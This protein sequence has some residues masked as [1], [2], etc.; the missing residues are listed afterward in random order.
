MITINAQMR[1][2]C[3][4]VLLS[5]LKTIKVCKNRQ[6]L[7]RIGSRDYLEVGYKKMTFGI[8]KTAR[9]VTQSRHFS[10]CATNYLRSR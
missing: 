8:S 7:F 2:L 9:E 3:Q 4:I 6:L 1:A 10:Y 5:H